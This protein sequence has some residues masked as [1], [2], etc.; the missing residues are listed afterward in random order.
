MVRSFDYAAYATLFGL[1]SSRGRATGVVRDEDRPSLLPWV[2]AWRSWTHNACLDGYLEV[3]A[4]ADFLPRDDEERNV[5]FRVLL[6]DQLL[7]EMA[8]QLPTGSAWLEIPLLGI[9]EAVASLPG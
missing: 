8:K 7:M 3:S 6:L 2:Q 5:L 9:L 4:G 1:T